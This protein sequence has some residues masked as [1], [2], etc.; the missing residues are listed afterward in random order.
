L[1]YGIYDDSGGVV[2]NEQLKKTAIASGS[3]NPAFLSGFSKKTDGT[4]I[5]YKKPPERHSL[6]IPV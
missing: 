6:Y 1:K 5:Q 2:S 4:A 3:N